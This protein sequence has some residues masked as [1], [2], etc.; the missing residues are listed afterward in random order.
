MERV[1][2]TSLALSLGG[3]KWIGQDLHRQC[4][5][6][7]LKWPKWRRPTIFN[8]GALSLFFQSHQ[9]SPLALV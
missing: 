8:S 4:E 3:Q 5:N 6:E 9:V 2:P 1:I 7:G